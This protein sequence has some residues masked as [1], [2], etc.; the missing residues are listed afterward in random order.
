MS[1]SRGN[2]GKT[3][4][5]LASLSKVVATMPAILLAIQAGK[6]TLHTPVEQIIPEFSNRNDDNRKSK[7]TVFHLLTHSSG[8]PHWRP[9]FVRLKGR[10]AYLRA[11]CKEPLAYDPG[12]NVVYSDLG[13]I[14]LGFILERIWDK[15]LSEIISE[16]IAVPLGLRHT[17]YC[18][19][20]GIKEWIA[21][22]E[23]GNQFEYKMAEDYAKLYKEG[24][25]PDDSFELHEEHVYD[26]H[27][28]R[29]IIQGAVHDANAYYGLNGVSGH[30]GLF[31]TM[32]DLLT[33]MKIWQE[34][35]LVSHSLVEMAC[36]RYIGG[37]T[38]SR[39]LGWESYSQ[40]L[41]GH[42]GF[43][44]TSIWFSPKDRITIIAL[45]NRVHPNVREGIQEWR[46][47][48]RNLMIAALLQ[49]GKELLK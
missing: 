14:L 38:I 27:W 48:Q 44:G 34:G 2:K 22:T 35:H 37:G 39:G 20:Q 30:A 21:P 43:T 40:T 12:M 25:L 18:P 13:F 23:K 45:T 47:R 31:S 5:D 41:Y 36:C 8:L 19:E 46:M 1:I 9:Y 49:Q 6:I 10:N 4:Y 33:Y 28:R 29:D 16:Q 3:M 17:V 42:T 32:D 26:F 24:K 15:E 7:I 11:I